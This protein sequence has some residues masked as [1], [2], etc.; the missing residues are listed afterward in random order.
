M[1]GLESFLLWIMMEPTWSPYIAHINQALC[2]CMDSV[3]KRFP[4]C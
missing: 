3:V 2:F 1:L 4:E